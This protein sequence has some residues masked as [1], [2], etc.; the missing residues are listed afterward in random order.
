MT[1]Y[2]VYVAGILV[3][4]GLSS[5]T[6]RVNGPNGT[7]ISSQVSAV[8]AAG[9]GPKSSAVVATPTATPAGAGPRSA[10]STPAGVTVPGSIDATGATDVSASLQAWVNAQADGSTLIFPSGATYKLGTFGIAIEARNNLTF[11]GYGATLHNYGGSAIRNSAFYTG[12][13]TGNSSGIK[14]L[15]FTIQGSNPDGGTI[16]AYHVGQESAMGFLLWKNPVGWEIADNTITDQW[17]LGIYV[18]SASGTAPWPQ[19]LNFHHNAIARTGLAALNVRNGI[20][21]TFADNTLTDSGGGGIDME[22]VTIPTEPLHSV[23]FQ[24]NVINRWMWSGG[25]TAHAISGDNLGDFN[26]I[27]VQSNVLLGGAQA[28]EAS[29]SYS[30]GVITFWGSNAKGS[31]II[32]S[33]NGSAIA[34]GLPSNAWAM[35]FNNVAGLTITNNN[36]TGMPGT[37]E[38]AHKVSCTSVIQTGNN[39]A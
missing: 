28:G 10:P 9:E 39:P 18:G 19:N 34:A 38:L 11:W 1:T 32:D 21:L 36:F 12:W 8:N 14:I 31:M 23:W 20:G 27:R 30:D 24:R 2:D 4:S 7:P 33:N 6:Y 35:R 22:D 29:P 37:P 16:N 13:T 25:A 5:P 26:D 15:G 3:A 17:G